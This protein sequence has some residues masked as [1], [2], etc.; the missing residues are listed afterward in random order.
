LGSKQKW[1]AAQDTDR[2]VSESEQY[3]MPVSFDVD[4]S[5]I[6]VPGSLYLPSSFCPQSVCD[7]QDD[8][9]GIFQ[10]VKRGSGTLV[11]GSLAGCVAKKEVL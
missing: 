9:G 4:A 10:K 1:Q 8:I 6:H 11:K 5:L 2:Y 7:E 3:H